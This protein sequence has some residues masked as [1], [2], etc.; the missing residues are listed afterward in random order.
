MS[1]LR[2]DKLEFYEI[3]EFKTCEKSV[4]FNEEPDTLSVFD[5]NFL[6]IGID[7]KM[8]IYDYKNFK[9]VKSVFIP[10]TVKVICVYQNKVYIACEDEIA[11]EYEIDNNENYK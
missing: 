8:Q 10:Y 9:N 6:L 1:I 7:N 5:D 4:E 2:K 11:N 3:E